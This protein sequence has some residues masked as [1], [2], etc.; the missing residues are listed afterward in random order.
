MWRVRMGAACPYKSQFECTGGGL[1][2]ETATEAGVVRAPGTEILVKILVP[3]F[4]SIPILV[5]NFD[6]APD[7]GI[8]ASLSPPVVAILTTIWT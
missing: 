6:L 4:L 2:R 8:S 1:V 3:P 7:P 5:C